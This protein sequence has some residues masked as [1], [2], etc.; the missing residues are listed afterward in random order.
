MNIKK[1]M[2]G[3]KLLPLLVQI[4][5]SPY[6]LNQRLYKYEICLKVLKMIMDLVLQNGMECL[7]VYRRGAFIHFCLVS[8]SLKCALMNF[9]QMFYSI[10]FKSKPLQEFFLIF[11]RRK[12]ARYLTLVLKM[13]EK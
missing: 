5:D 8:G 1:D 12:N 9:F 11:F 13:R 6:P 7:S 2:L 4:M 3:S 10:K